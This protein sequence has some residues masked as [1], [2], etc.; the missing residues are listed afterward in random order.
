[1]RSWRFSSGSAWNTGAVLEVT[2]LVIGA[3]DG[4][5]F[6]LGRFGLEEE[7]LMDLVKVG[8]ESRLR[9]SIF[10]SKKFFGKKILK[11]K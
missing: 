1:M 10:S 4:G 5:T 9:R 3:S 2:I 7:N 8:T 11:K 6:L